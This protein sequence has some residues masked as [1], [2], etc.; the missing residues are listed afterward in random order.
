MAKNINSAFRIREILNSVKEKAITKITHDVWG[1]A[2]NISEKN[3]QKKV[4]TVSRCLADLHDEVELVRNDMLTLGYTSNLYEP[5]LNKCNGIFSV[6]SIMG[7]WQPLKLQITPDII[8]ALG[9]CSEII[10]NEEDLIEQAS[11]DELSGLAGDLRETLKDSVLPPYT[12]SI[13]EKHL[14]KIEGAI[15]SYRA[16]GAKALEDVMQS[17]YGEIVA[18]ETVLQKEKGSEELSKLSKLWQKTKEVLDG[19]V[20]IN[21]RIGAVQGMTKKGQKLIEFLQDLNV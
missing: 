14:S 17:A 1:E 8:I 19:A 9:F 11:L 13:I 10:P 6:Q 4:F 2:F 18:N 21:K 16:V 3:I 7:K 15:S 12:K 20:S 5:S